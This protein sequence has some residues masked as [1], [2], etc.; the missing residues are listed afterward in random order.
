[1][2][3]FH[4][5]GIERHRLATD[6][7]GV[8][9]LVGGH[10][11]PLKCRYCLNPQCHGD[12]FKIFSVASLYEYVRVDSLYFEATGGGITFGGGEPLIQ[13]EFIL[14]F[15]EYVRNHG[16][17]WKFS[18]ETSLAVDFSNT[19]DLKNLSRFVDRF[20]VDVKDMNPDI[21]SA[22]TGKTPEKMI[23]NLTYLSQICPEKLSVRLPL[24]PAYNSS[25]DVD[26]SA[27]FIEKLGI[28]S[29]ERF[30]YIKD[31]GASKFHKK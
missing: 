17:R 7:D 31:I 22:Y 16:H 27:E 1:M 21:Y 11:C 14:D 12:R 29:V 3:E 9:T 4:A 6:G 24:I 18:I 8:T 5:I 13:A 25:A 26:L 30:I 20:I 19:D 15:I 28:N 10:G 2:S 23:A